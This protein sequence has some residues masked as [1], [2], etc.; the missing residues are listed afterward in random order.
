MIDKVFRIGTRG[1][2][3]ALA[4]T[5]E[6]IQ[7]LEAVVPQC[8]FEIVPIKTKGDLK[9]HTALTKLGS[10]GLFAREVETE[11]LNGTIDFAV[12]SAKDLP[13]KLAPQL[14]ITAVP[15]RALAYD[16]LVLKKP[17]ITAV[18]QLAKGAVIG[19]GSPRRVSLLTQLRHDLQFK[20]IRGNVP[21]RLEKLQTQDFDG[22]I[23]AAAG[24]QRLGLLDASRLNFVPLPM[25]RFVPAPGQGLLALECHETNAEV[26][27]LLAKINDT[28][29]YTALTCER[30][31][32]QTLE[33]DCT[34]PLG[35]H[36]VT[37][38]TGLT[39]T[40][41]LGDKQN[42]QRGVFASGHGLEP[43]ALGRQLALEV[44]KKV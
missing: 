9:P 16:V 6:V 35:C 18:S 8:R 38:K 29:A 44:I 31:F 39:A 17:G 36:C 37:T 20:N 26:K 23:L 22:L 19:T 13:A 42:S 28:A 15:P 34:I 1:S 21:T 33:G 4:Q 14:M 24:L 43:A 3:L 27:A 10:N 11:L 7:R 30:S 25:D 12:H 2:R 41:F 5:N 32:L 40:A